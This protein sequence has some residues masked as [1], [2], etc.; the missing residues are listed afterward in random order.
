VAAVRPARAAARIPVVAA[1]S[2]RR[3]Q[4]QAVGVAWAKSSPSATF[5]GI[6]AIDFLLI[7]VGVPTVA[8]VGGWL[9]AGREPAAIASQPLE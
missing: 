2:G 8:A 1:L 5:C 3:P 7:L 4:P 9:L 6:P